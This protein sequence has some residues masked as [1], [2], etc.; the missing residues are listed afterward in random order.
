MLAAQGE[1]KS[2]VLVTRDPVFEEF[3]VQTLW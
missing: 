1:L 3:P 2:L